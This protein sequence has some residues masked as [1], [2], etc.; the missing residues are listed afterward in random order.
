[1]MFQRPTGAGESNL[2]PRNIVPIKQ[3]HLQTFCARAELLRVKTGAI[4]QLHLTDARNG[5]D[6]QQS[7]ENDVALR[8]LASLASRA[9]FRGFVFFQISGG[10]SP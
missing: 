1:M 9:L 8:F 7:V 3:F 2:R 4:Q 10:Q 6:R 5:I